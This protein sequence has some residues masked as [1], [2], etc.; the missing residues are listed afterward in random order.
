[1]YFGTADLTPLLPQAKTTP[2]TVTIFPSGFPST[3]TP[4]LFPPIWGMLSITNNDT[5]QVTILSP[6]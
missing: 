4:V 6:Q 1:M 3:L 2:V 5:Q